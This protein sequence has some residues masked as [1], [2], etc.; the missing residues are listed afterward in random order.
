VDESFEK[1]EQEVPQVEKSSKEILAL[2]DA[3]C[4]F[5]VQ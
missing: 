3:F 4:V 5:V 2:V 1:Q